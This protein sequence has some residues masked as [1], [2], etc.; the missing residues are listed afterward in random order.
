MIWFKDT[1]A[2][3]GTPV[4]RTMDFSFENIIP[5]CV[6]E[7]VAFDHW[8]KDVFSG[9][10]VGWLH[11]PAAVVAQFRSGK[12]RAIITT[13][14]LRSASD[15]DPMARFLLASLA[16][17]VDSARCEPDLQIDLDPLQ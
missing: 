11:S 4:P 5:K 1:A 15:H 7:G 6:L 12:G 14:P 17:Y 3:D 9:I 2:F 10:F 8:D 13:L 16:R